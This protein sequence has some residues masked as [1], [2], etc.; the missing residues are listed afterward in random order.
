MPSQELDSH[1]YTRF[2]I[3][4]GKGEIIIVTDALKTF[5][6][7]FYIA[8]PQVTL[9]MIIQQRYFNSN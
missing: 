6:T 1:R 7:M 5:Y 2:K 4:G 3:Q 8:F 9:I